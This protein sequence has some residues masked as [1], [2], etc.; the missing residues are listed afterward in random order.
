M[1]QGGREFIPDGAGWQVAITIKIIEAFDDRLKDDGSGGSLPGAVQAGGQGEVEGLGLLN[2]A[3]VAPTDRRKDIQAAALRQVFDQGGHDRIERTGLLPRVSVT[4]AGLLG[5]IAG[6]EIVPLTT[7][8]DLPEDGVEHGAG[9]PRRP[10]TPPVVR[11]RGGDDLLNNLPLFVGQIHNGSKSTEIQGNPS[12]SGQV[13][14][15]F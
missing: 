1:L 12:G 9:V 2:E 6:G 4:A 8:A 7:S 14:F 13:I 10:A 15:D 5:R 11:G 3:N